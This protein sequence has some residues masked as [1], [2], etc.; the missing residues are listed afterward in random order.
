MYLAYTTIETK[1]KKWGKT[2]TS[3]EE[4][5]TDLDSEITNHLSKAVLSMFD[6]G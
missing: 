2:K 1:K 6:G 3:T 5:L 4:N